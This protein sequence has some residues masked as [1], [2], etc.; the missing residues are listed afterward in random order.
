[1]FPSLGGVG[2]L[3]GLLQLSQTAVV[4]VQAWNGMLYTIHFPNRPAVVFELDPV[5]QTEII[6][7]IPPARYNT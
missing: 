6:A 4:L 7:L 1:M 3:F 5:D 2:T